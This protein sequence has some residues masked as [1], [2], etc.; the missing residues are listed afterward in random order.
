MGE[1]WPGGPA[2]LPA[3]V[4]VD[5]VEYVLEERTTLALLHIV[6]SGNWLDI[7]PGMLSAA[8][9]HALTVRVTDP[10]D[11]LD[12]RDLFEVA[13]VAG[14][15]LAGAI[16]TPG[17]GPGVPVWMGAVRLLRTVVVKWLAFDGWCLTQGYTPLEGPLWRITAASYRWLRDARSDPGADPKRLALA[18]AQLDAEIWAAP[19]KAATAAAAPQPHTADAE[20]AAARAV[21]AEARLGGGRP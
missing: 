1:L 13:S 14:A 4:A 12:Y 3:T 8:D 2:V 16:H 15:R 11:P 21:L 18:L 9:Q 6:A 5:G 7:V 17:S 20:R 19:G 10:D